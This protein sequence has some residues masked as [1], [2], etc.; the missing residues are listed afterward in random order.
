[1]VGYRIKEGD[2]DIVAGG[3]TCQGFSFAGAK[4]ANDPETASLAPDSFVWMPSNPS[5][6]SLR[7]SR[8]CSSFTAA[9]YL[10]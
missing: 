5:S 4:E 6:Q 3:P 7:M 8:G 10:S 1:M 2:I 9:S